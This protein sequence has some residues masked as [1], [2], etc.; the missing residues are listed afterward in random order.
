MP[1]EIMT[2]SEMTN[3]MATTKEDKVK[4]PDAPKPKP[5]PEKQVASIPPEDLELTEPEI[6]PPEPDKLPEPPP[7]EPVPVPLCA[8]VEDPPA[9]EDV[10]SAEALPL[11]ADV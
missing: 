8:V 11:V 2:I 7:P 9:E 6:A 10:L 5:E 4:P 3:I 1:V